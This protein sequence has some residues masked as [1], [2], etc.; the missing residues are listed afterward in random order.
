[1]IKP[2][3]IGLKIIGVS[4]VLFGLAFICLISLG[5]SGFHEALPVDVAGMVTSFSGL[6][7]LQRSFKF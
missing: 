3:G 7:C 5:A 2:K 4:L 6:L 1:M